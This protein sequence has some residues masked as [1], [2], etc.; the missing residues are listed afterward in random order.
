MDKLWPKFQRITLT[1][2][3]PWGIVAFVVCVA[4]LVELFIFGGVNSPLALTRYLLWGFFL[5]VVSGVTFLYRRYWTIAAEQRNLEKR[6]QTS[7]QLVGESYQRLDLLFQVNQK[8]V[9]AGDENEVIQPVLQL[10]VDLTGAEGASFVPLDEHGQPQSAISHGNLPFSEMKSWV[11]YLASPGVR[12]RCRDCE[13]MDVVEKPANCPLLRNPFYGSG[14]IF[15]FPV[16]RGERQFGVMNLFLDEQTVLDERTGAYLKALMDQTALGLDGI[17][18]RR[19]ELAALRQ[20]QVLRQK[21]DLTSLL[22]GLLENIH[23]TLEADFTMMVVPQA[24]DFASKKELSQ[25]DL[26]ENTQAFV[27]G[28]LQGVITSGETVLLGEFAGDQP[29]NPGLSSLIAAPLISLEHRVVGAV[30]VGSRR[31]RGYSQRQVAL[32]KTVAGQVALVVQNANLVAELEYKTMM[33]ERT[34]LAREIHDGLAQTLAFLKLQAA[35]QRSY[36]E[37]G[38]IE[39]AQ[40]S[41]E[42]FYKTLSEAYQDAREAIDGLRISTAESQVSTWLQQTVAEFQEI[43]GLTVYLDAEQIHSAFAP[44]IQAQLIRILQEALSNVRK[45]ADAAQVWIACQ[46]IKGDLILEVRDDGIGFLPEDV[47]SPSRHGLR[48]MRERAELIGADFQVI[49]RPHEGTIVRIRLPVIGL[50]EVAS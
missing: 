15:C 31:K 41:L 13:D 33:Q 35:Q 12:S 28:I 16:Q 4:L 9:E 11:E 36:L 48:G 21:T 43:S 5:L 22:N 8:F 49:S 30:L 26:S 38:E 34:R 46:Q 6:L 27:K 1:G 20:M 50:E 10:L 2:W 44:E 37:R 32:L 7:E 25:G 24:G 29:S 14:N 47:A 45:H 39:R 3:F 23:Q 18:F 42:R 19:R 40:S 17:R